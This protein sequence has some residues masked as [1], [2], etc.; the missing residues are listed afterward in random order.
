MPELKCD[1]VM[2]G[3]ITSGIV[4][5]KAV[6][7]LAK[8]Y[9]FQSIGGTSAGAIAAAATA[10]AEYGR[11]QGNEKAFDE[12]EKLPE[13]LGERMA[14]GSPRL[15]TLFKPQP[16]TEALFHTLLAFLSRVSEGIAEAVRRYSLPG[17][18]GALPVLIVLL[19]FFS[20]AN[21]LAGNLV[22]AVLGLLPWLLLAV[23]GFFI[24]VVWGLVRDVKTKVPE[25]FYGLC[26]GH[27][28]GALTPWLHGLFQ[29]LSGKTDGPLT[30]GD[31]KAKGV[32][33]AMMTTSLTHG[34]PYRL[35]LEGRAFFFREAD[36]LRLFPKDVVDWMK[37]HAPAEE[38]EKASDEFIRFP[39][40][41][42]LPVIVGTRMSLS[43][44]L[45]ISAVP[46]YAIDY[47]LPKEERKPEPCWF[48]DGGISSNFP[49]HFFDSPLPGWP[50]F[51]INL[52]YLDGR[53]GQKEE[54]WM[55][56]DNA[57]GRQELWNRFEKKGLGGFFGA[58]L[59]SMQNWQDNTQMRMPGYRDR[60]AH[61]GLGPDEGGLNLDMPP[62]R[63]SALSDRGKRAGEELAR[64]FRPG[65]DAT[66]N[67]ENHRWVR[68][69]S[70]MAVLEQMFGK[71]GKRL[72]PAEPAPQKGDPPYAELVA[73][74]DP[75]SYDWKREP[76]HAWAVEATK[77]LQSLA[78]AW[79][80][81][82]ERFS[83]GAPRPTPELRARPKI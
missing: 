33:L 61:V 68:F 31:L 66:L 8:T 77:K 45:L 41:D 73:R 70:T 10:A 38:G 81:S 25:N 47:E 16:E 71:I 5:P 60:V 37:A 13:L 19:P 58:I 29:K 9:S 78:A 22:S 27:G 48:S 69:R 53:P 72:D 51:A 65:S 75:V 80:A 17:L 24:G 64:R 59:E 28:D 26:T 63:I 74:R 3:G 50:T 11:R 67:W 15:L 40:A 2:K 49:V 30:F 42:D 39:A 52:R 6:A 21:F 57:G 23:V 14:G 82:P 46:L 32:E 55:P 56:P 54:V 1:V 62:E 35:P 36:F 43:F 83:E 18:V 20:V 4:Y 12:L 79:T 7:E 76:Q 34:R 44:P